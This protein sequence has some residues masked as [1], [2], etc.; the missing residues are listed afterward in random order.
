MIVNSYEK[1]ARRLIKCLD[2]GIVKKR[3]WLIVTISI[4]IYQ[5]DM[6]ELARSFDSGLGRVVKEV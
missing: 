4:N 2:C 6:K 3:A 1:S 5:A